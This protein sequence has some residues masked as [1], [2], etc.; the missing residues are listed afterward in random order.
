MIAPME[1]ECMLTKHSISHTLNVSYILWGRTYSSHCAN[2][3][4]SLLIVTM[5]QSM[6][7][8]VLVKHSVNIDSQID[9][10]ISRMNVW[11]ISVMASNAFL[12]Y[13]LSEY[14]GGRTS[15]RTLMMECG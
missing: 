2:E 7:F 13:Q 9:I 4:C 1:C 14:Q 8:S 12:A 11:A 3:T 6:V 10:P 15:A 5:I